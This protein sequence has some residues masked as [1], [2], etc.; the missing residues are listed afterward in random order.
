MDTKL[1]LTMVAATQVL[2][3]YSAFVAQSLWNWFAVKAFNVPEAPYWAVFGLLLLV[4]LLQKD[5]EHYI[6][7][8]QWKM[9]LTLLEA[10]VPE[11]KQTSVHEKLK[12]QAE[13]M[14]KELVGERLIQKV[15]STTVA[16]GLG[17]VINTLLV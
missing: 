10:C 3:L 17:W 7:D 1:M 6:E 5:Q 2:R 14:W 8:E 15:I 13:G 16:L 11:D 9:Q 12:S 4:G